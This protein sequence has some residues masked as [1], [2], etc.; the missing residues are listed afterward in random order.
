M[1]TPEELRLEYVQNS[2]S[3]L[4]IPKDLRP[5]AAKAAAT[6]S[7]APGVKHVLGF[8]DAVAQRRAAY[9]LVTPVKFEDFAKEVEKEVLPTLYFAPGL[10]ADV[11]QTLNIKPMF[12][13]MQSF[14]AGSGRDSSYNFSTVWGSDSLFFRGSVDSDLTVSAHMAARVTPLGAAAV[15]RALIHASAR[16]SQVVLET[17]IPLADSFL[18]LRAV[19]PSVLDTKLTGVFG[20]NF[21]QSVTTR[22]TLGL[23]GMWQRANAVQPA[24]ASF[25]MAARYAGPNFI[26]SGS[27][28]ALGV[29]GLS[30]AQSLTDKITAAVSTNLDVYG[31]AAR[32]NGEPVGSATTTTVGVKVDYPDGSV[33]RTK[34]DSTGKLMLVLERILAET[35]KFTLS[36]ELDQATGSCRLGFGLQIESTSES[37]ETAMRS[38]QMMDPKE[39]RKYMAN[40]P[41]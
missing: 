40:S 37:A 22:L 26:G 15:S 19:S 14:L 35:M 27:L 5:S 16:Q 31:M 29:V 21:S 36:S 12:N 39:A 41:Q 6:L 38:L 24:S 33:I 4:G 8:Y 34:V 1:A 17:D 7:S 11:N 13:V 9:G 10:R 23:A 25:D 20:F 28:S 30:F 2:L 32:M 18:C 3:A